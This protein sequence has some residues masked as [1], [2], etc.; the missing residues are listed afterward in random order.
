MPSSPIEGCILSFSGAADAPLTNFFASTKADSIFLA[1][2]EKAY[3]R[4]RTTTLSPLL[5]LIPEEQR[6][7]ISAKEKDKTLQSCTPIWELLDRNGATRDSIL[8][9]VGGGILTD[10]A[11]FAAAVYKRGIRTVNIPTTLMG[12]V[13]AAIGGKTAVDHIGIKNKIGAFHFPIGIFA[14]A[15]F[16]TTLDAREYLSGF[17]EILKHAVL[18][19]NDAWDNTRAIDLDEEVDNGPSDAFVRLIAE[20]ASY[21]STIVGKDPYEGGLRR[22]LNLGHTIGHALESF[23]LEKVDRPP[24]SH[25]EAVLSGLIIELYLSCLLHG[26]P[27]HRLNELINFAKQYYRAYP[28]DCKEYKRIVDY[29]R[30]DKKNTSDKIRFVAMRD[31]GTVAEL[32]EITEKKISEG[33]DFYREVF[34]C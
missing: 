1:V 26:F 27:S 13:D 14:D 20:N 5:K 8:V 28:I 6:I 31:I 7:I 29:A 2:D 24:L 18:M 32:T 15:D 23:S 12:M 22:S 11:G 30:H 19:G 34:G 9:S 33:L 25:G 3:K 10:L 4:H 16:L 21:K 17:A